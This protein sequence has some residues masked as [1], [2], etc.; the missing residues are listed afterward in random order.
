MTANPYSE[1]VLRTTS[2][3]AWLYLHEGGTDLSPRDTYIY[4]V[5]EL[6][7]VS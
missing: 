3:T 4:R 6:L 1:A 5:Y 7:T 2:L